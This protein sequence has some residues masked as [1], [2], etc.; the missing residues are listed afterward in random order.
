MESCDARGTSLVCFGFCIGLLVLFRQVANVQGRFGRL[1]AANQYS[2]YVWQELIIVPIQLGFLALPLC[3]FV[4]FVAVS[5][6]AAP[7][8][9]ILSW[10]VRRIPVVRKAL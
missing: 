6:L 4:K 10:L 3:P 8:I 2:A 1:L 7:L 5:A 9:F